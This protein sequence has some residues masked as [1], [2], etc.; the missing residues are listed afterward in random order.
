ME[1]VTYFLKSVF[2]FQVR[3]YIIRLRILTEKKHRQIKSSAY[4]KYEYGHLGRW[5]I[6]LEKKSKK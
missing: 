1:N 6:K 3:Q 5:Y 2:F 4:K